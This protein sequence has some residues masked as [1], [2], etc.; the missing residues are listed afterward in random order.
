M[1]N[2]LVPVNA[3]AYAKSFFSLRFF[4][5]NL[6][7]N[8]DEITKKARYFLKEFTSPNVYID[9]D[10]HGYMPHPF[11]RKDVPNKK[12][13]FNLLKNDIE[14]YLNTTKLCFSTGMIIVTKLIKIEQINSILDE[15]SRELTV[16]NIDYKI[17][18][19][20][21]LKVLNSK[22]LTADFVKRFNEDAVEK[23]IRDFIELKAHFFNKKCLPIY[24][25]LLNQIPLQLQMYQTPQKKIN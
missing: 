5:A 25:Q 15:I 23:Q 14:N 20:K 24:R 2:D 6:Q 17:F 10:T 12:I 21:F 7:E 8:E 1:N 13:A 22:C 4:L 3:N 16:S 19:E 11:F 18:I 9:A